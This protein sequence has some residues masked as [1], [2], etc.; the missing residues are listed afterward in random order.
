[1]QNQ[2]PSQDFR[3]WRDRGQSK[4]AA[5]PELRDYVLLCF[6]C[7]LCGIGLGYGLV[8]AGRFALGR[9]PSA[10]SRLMH[11]NERQL[12]AMIL[13]PGILGGLFGLGYGLRECWKSARKSNMR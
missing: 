1:M 9:G 10:T 3:R 8:F 5:K 12:W 7:T 11:A 4:G 13:L 6:F 2:K